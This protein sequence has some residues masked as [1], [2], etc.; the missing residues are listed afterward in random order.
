MPVVQRKPF[1]QYHRTRRSLQQRRRGYTQVGRAGTSAADIGQVSR[2]YHRRGAH[3]LVGRLQRLP[4][5]PR[6]AAVVCGFHP[7][8]HRETKNHPYDIVALPNLRLQS[9]HRRRHDR[10][11]RICSRPRRYD[12]R[13][14]SPQ[15]HSLEGR[16]RHAR[17]PLNLRPS[18][19]I[20]AWQ[21]HLRL[22]NR[23]PQCARRE[24][25]SSPGRGF[26]RRRRHLF[27]AHLQRGARPRL[28]LPLL[29]Q[30]SGRLHAR[31]DGGS[32]PQIARP[33]RHRRRRQTAHGRI[34]LTLPRRIF[35]R[36]HEPLQRSRPQLSQR[37][38]ETIFGRTV[39]DK[40]MPTTQ[41]LP[42][43]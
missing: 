33:A 42:H 31:L 37:L 7:R 28:R 6:G 24:L 30:R 20:V 41:P 15:H 8:H 19:R 9:Y 5:N 12:H 11:S 32:Q 16:R 36:R 35:L 17:R 13:T 34:G 10:P 25:L 2:V 1:T 39:V 21:H 26:H 14:R 43:L 38:V 40:T 23:Q 18:G 4:Q 29:Y 22:D 27:A 3:A